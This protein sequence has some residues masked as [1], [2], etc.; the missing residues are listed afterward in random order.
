MH[1]NKHSA[2][3]HEH[4]HKHP[5]KQKVAHAAKRH[6]KTGQALHLKPEHAIA[7]D[8]KQM[9]VQEIMTPAPPV[10]V[11][12]NTAPFN[13]VVENQAVGL[14]KNAIFRFQIT[15]AGTDQRLMP[16]GYWF[17]RIEW[18]ERKHNQEIARYHD[19][20]LHW[21]VMSLPPNM[22]KIWAVEGNFNCKTGKESNYVQR[23]GETRNYYLLQ[24]HLWLNGFGLDM[25]RMRSD[26]EIRFY[27]RGDIRVD[28]T[29]GTAADAQLQEVR[30]IADSEMMTKLSESAT[31]SMR[32]SSVNQ[33]NFLD[34]QR[35]E[36]VGRVIAAGEEFSVDLEQ[37]NHMSAFLAITIRTS[38]QNRDSL[39]FVP[40]GPRG[41][42][43]HVN[44]HNKSML[45]DGTPIDER[46]MRDMVQTDLFPWDFAK[47]NA[48]Y[49]IPFTKDLMGCWSGKINGYH[50]FRGDRERINMVTGQAPTE[51]SYTMEMKTP[52]VAGAARLRYKGILSTP[53]DWTT[54][55]YAQLTAIAN[56]MQ[57][58]QDEGIEVVIEDTALVAANPLAAAFNSRVRLFRRGTYSTTANTGQ[59]YP[60]TTHGCG[61][62]DLQVNETGVTD[63]VYDNFVQGVEGFVAGTYNITVY[64][65]FYRF[66][67]EYTGFLESE[68]I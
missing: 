23:V 47:Y 53:F 61:V 50:R 68:D 6:H 20:V 24:P 10:N 62:L 41:T 42:I 64:S 9:F 48:I 27:P 16:I 11:L 30:W 13:F 1:K 54:V 12:A 55:T 18:R 46:F 3:V 40:L 59:P 34:T 14:V 66:V 58:L 28:P 31:L 60:Q 57:S 38:N 39:R 51:T 25:S 22:L 4:A 63:V 67:N 45:G 26:L 29:V 37:F 32:M 35:W 49:I 36:D 44:V 7:Y 52:P 19:D 17:E 21:S 8:G 33:Q 2:T 56:E 15:M 43:D 5:K 65:F